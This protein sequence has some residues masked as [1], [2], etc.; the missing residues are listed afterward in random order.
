MDK[1]KEAHDKL[2]SEKS[3]EDV[4]DEI[5]CPFCNP[6]LKLDSEEGGNVET[7]T[8][9]ELNAAVA[10]AVAEAI[11]P[12]QLELEGFKKLQA[13]DETSAQLASAQADAD[14][15]R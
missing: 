10:T 8:K 12:L 11:A 7:F 3:E 5:S 6:E 1:L 13:E 14:A 15:R 4:H 9:D 2:L